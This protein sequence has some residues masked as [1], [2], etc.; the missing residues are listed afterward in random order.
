MWIID[1]VPVDCICH[2]LVMII[3]FYFY[4]TIIENMIFPFVE[5]DYLLF[6]T[7]KHLIVVNL[8]LLCSC[9]V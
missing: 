1:T 5:N 2:G 7:G 6:L 3:S 4:G 9:Y 8:L